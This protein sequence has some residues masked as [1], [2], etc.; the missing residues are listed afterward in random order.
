MLLINTLQGSKVEHGGFPD[1]RTNEIESVHEN[2]VQC[3]NYYFFIRR[4]YRWQ[5]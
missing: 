5:Y 4:S 1:L 2:I 3:C